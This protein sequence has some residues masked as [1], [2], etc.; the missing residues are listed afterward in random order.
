MNPRSPIRGYTALVLAGRR[1]PDDPLAAAANAPHRA[2][3][4]IH[5]TPMLER[6]LRSLVATPCIGD[7]IV[8]IDEKHLLDSFPT[9]QELLEGND[10]IA[11]VESAESPSRSVLRALERVP[12]EQPLLV[13]TAD[14]ALLSVEML[15]SF[16]GRAE[17][18]GGD[19]AIALVASRVL[20]SRFPDA[21]RTYLRFADER[22]SGA[23]LFAFLTPRAH[24]AVRF[25]RRAESFRKQ[26]WRL[27]AAFGLR[28]LILFLTRRLDLEA[29]FSEVSKR[30]GVRVH[31][32]LMEQAE[33]AVDVDK[34]SDLELV[35][36]ILSRQADDRVEPDQRTS[37]PSATK[38]PLAAS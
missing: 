38:P 20:V 21:V 35:K 8:S 13:T 19:L 14:H 25:W 31:P 7:I 12:P 16:L 3:L 6:V 9:L 10:R 36:Q 28:P 32:I 4:D 37:S 23:N 24:E 1:G 26:P 11:V 2:L 18:R 27:V 15:E 30:L 34:L 29:A 17:Q 22:Y 5:G 33:A